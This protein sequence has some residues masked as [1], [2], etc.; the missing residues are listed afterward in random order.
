MKTELSTP[1]KAFY[2]LWIFSLGFLV[3]ALCIGIFCAYTELRKKT[4]G[5]DHDRKERHSPIAKLAML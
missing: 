5:A 1:Q 4:R 2:L 3:I